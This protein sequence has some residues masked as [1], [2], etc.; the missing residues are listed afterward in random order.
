MI[1]GHPRS[2][3][4]RICRCHRADVNL[5]LPACIAAMRIVAG[6]LDA[7]E[8]CYRAELDAVRAAWRQRVTDAAR[9]PR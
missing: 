4:V 3:G 9:L 5:R 6:H 2:P 7:W 8:R 1:P